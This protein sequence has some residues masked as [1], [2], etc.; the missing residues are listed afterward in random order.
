MR[1]R[2]VREGGE[3]GRVRGRGV[4][5]GKGYSSHVIERVMKV[6]KTLCCSEDSQHTLCTVHYCWM[7]SILDT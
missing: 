1:G 7:W 4:R 5:E 2:G 3:G 6:S